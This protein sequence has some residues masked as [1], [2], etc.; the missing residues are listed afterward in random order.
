MKIKNVRKIFGPDSLQP[1]FHQLSNA[2]FQKIPR[3]VPEKQHLE[4]CRIV[5]HRGVHKRRKALENTVAAFQQA[6]DLGVWGIEFDIRWT[7]DLK[8]VVF[9]DPNLMRLFGNPKPIHAFSRKKLKHAYPTIPPLEEVVHQFG[10]HLHLMIEIKAETYP[11]PAGQ[12]DVLQKILGNLE[13]VRDYHFM[14]L[15]PDMFRFVDF[16]PREAMLP[17]AQ[18]RFREFSRLA[19]RKC[20]GGIT[21]HYLFLSNALIRK[22][23]DIG[24]MAGTGFVKSRNC[25]F[26]EINRG[27]DWIFSDHAEKLQGIIQQYL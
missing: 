26:R 8:P 15:D 6:K 20:Y 5:A 23:R 12:S 9:H 1:Y 10:G 2:L 11:K 16:A 13:P 14:S 21:G 3:P 27:V 4:G 7:G 17:I 22:H 18:L 24:Q 19:R 25:L